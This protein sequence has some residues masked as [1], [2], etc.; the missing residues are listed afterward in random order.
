MFSDEGLPP[1]DNYLAEDVSIGLGLAHV[2]TTL[3]TLNF[4][5]P[6]PRLLAKEF[7]FTLEEQERCRDVRKLPQLFTELRT[8]LPAM[9]RYLTVARL[10]LECPSIWTTLSRRHK[11]NA[12]DLEPAALAKKYRDCRLCLE[13]THH[14]IRRVMVRN[15]QLTEEMHLQRLA[16]QSAFA[17]L[18]HTV[19]AGMAVT[20]TPESADFGTVA[21]ALAQLLLLA[22]SLIEHLSLISEHAL[23][24]GFANLSF[25]Q[26]SV[27]QPLY[28]RLI[29]LPADTEIRLTELE[30]LVLYQAAQV[31]LLALLVEI[32]PEGT[33][34]DWVASRIL[35]PDPPQKY[36][37]T[38]EQEQLDLVN[39]TGPADL[40]AFCRRVQEHFGADHPDFARADAET[41]ELTELL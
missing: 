21:P 31:T 16:I 9:H 30:A 23:V 5:D 25:V 32:T 34:A 40:Q 10:A 18:G 6:L 14:L 15:P 28:K 35:K 37:S 19:R 29:E 17:R 22:V 36:L 3:L 27:R 39:T 33:W 11:T 24:L 13:V 12:A 7:G 4:H 20:D 41:R 26:A 8:G 1:N 2:T 38:Y